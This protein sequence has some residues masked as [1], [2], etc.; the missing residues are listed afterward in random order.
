MVNNH[1]YYLLIKDNNILESIMELKLIKF[2]RTPI[3]CIA[4]LILVG[5]VNKSKKTDYRI[6]DIEVIMNRKLPTPDKLIYF[7]NPPLSNKQ[8]VDFIEIVDSVS[9]IIEKIYSFKSPLKDSTAFK[10]T[11]TQFIGKYNDP[12]SLKE[13]LLRG[14][15]KIVY[16]NGKEKIYE[17]IN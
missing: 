10:I 15:F 9:N 7:I 13:D 2:M 14:K 5:C 8:D 11:T 6:V 1:L 12:I 16:K 17:V 4:L 3:L